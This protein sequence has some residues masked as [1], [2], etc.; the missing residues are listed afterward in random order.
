LPSPEAISY[1]LDS[2]RSTKEKD[3]RRAFISIQMAIATYSKDMTLAANV[4][5]GD[6]GA[7]RRR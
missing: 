1:T 6:L 4:E 3:M 5:L 2:S 7:C